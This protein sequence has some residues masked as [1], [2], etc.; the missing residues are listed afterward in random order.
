M[1]IVPDAMYA[2]G[3]ALLGS[4]LPSVCYAGG[5]WFWCDP[6]S[7][8][9]GG[10]AETPAT[11]N[12]SL[13]SCYA[14]CRDGYND[15]VFLIGRASGAA[16]TAALAWSNS[17]CHLVGLSADLPGVGQRCRVTGS[18]TA[19][20]TSLV[21]FSGS[22]CVVK[23]IQF[24]NGTDADVDSGSV[25]VSGNRNYFENCFVVGMGHATPAA[26]AGSYSMTVSGAENCFVKTAIGVDTI[27]RSAAN[28][29]LIV[30]G[31]RNSFYG[32]ELRSDS[33]TAGKFL[34]KIDASK[35][36]R[37]IRFHDCLF[38]NYSTNWATG[39]T[40]AFNM[41]GGNTHFVILSG[42]CQFV[43][44]TGIADVVTHIYGAG[45]AP[46][47]GMFLSTQPTT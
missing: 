16:L 8:T 41:S 30:S 27:V 13:A 46:N 15:G 17:Y 42:N 5:K 4:G 40:N 43:G 18:A 12:S 34:V 47:A 20:L 3:G 39:I 19:D 38:Y 44:C 14:K 33:V 10:D 26:R 29:E 21:T 7:G 2:Y 23:N 35:D 36:L 1:S 37:D 9:A 22:G 11:A 32:C 24:F 31:E 45:A 6:T 25:I 28:S